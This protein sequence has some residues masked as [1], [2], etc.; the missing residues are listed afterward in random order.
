[1]INR[2]A[3]AIKRSQKES[4]LLRTI[5]QLYHQASRDDVDLQKAYVTRVQ[6]S[7][8]KTLC[9]V[10]FYMAEGKE[11]FKSIVS[12]IALYKPSMRK[13]LAHE[14]NGRYTCELAFRFDEQFEKTERIERLI[15]SLATEPKTAD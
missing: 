12:K 6:L 7:P 3:S 9:T 1:M 5:S 2:S 10:F 11:A 14:I 8:S 15:D 13:A 4:L